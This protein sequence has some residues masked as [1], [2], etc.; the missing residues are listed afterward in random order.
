MGRGC[1]LR[2]GKTEVIGS[3]TEFGSENSSCGLKN[4]IIVAVFVVAEV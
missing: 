1:K 2:E 4:Q 3:E